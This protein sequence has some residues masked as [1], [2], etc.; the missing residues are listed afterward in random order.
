MNDLNFVF[1]D[2]KRMLADMLDV[3]RD[4]ELAHRRLCDFIWMA[5]NPPKNDND[6]LREL[7]KTPP[8]LWGKVRRGLE[9]KGW[10][11]LGRFLAHR[12][13]IDSLNSASARHAEN[14]NRTAAA[15][16]RPMMVSAVDAAT[17][18]VRYSLTPKVAA[19]VTP[20]VT[21][22]VTDS[23]TKVHWEGEGKG[24]GTAGPTKPTFKAAPGDS[25]GGDSP[26]G[27]A[28]A[29]QLAK[30]ILANGGGW[31]YDNG[32]VRAADFD[33]RSLVTVLRP[34]VG[35]VAESDVLPAFAAAVREAHQQAVDF[36]NGP[37]PVRKPAALAVKLF[38]ERLTQLAKPL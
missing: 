7:T 20:A 24:M 28:T 36:Q 31:F 2:A 30:D 21:R 11:V 12:G 17:G 37:N 1:Y 10:V 16:G 26:P 3:D 6:V 34:F 38:R 14:Y 18:I 32:R 33:V 8:Q 4:T 27:R 23:V 25:Q 29:E 15:G 13:A 9:E 35:R 19:S 5:E 22:P